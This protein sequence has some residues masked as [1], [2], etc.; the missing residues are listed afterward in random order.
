LQFLRVA[1][2]HVLDVRR[3]V[4]RSDLVP[5][6]LLEMVQPIRR[7]GPA[8]DDLDE[9]GGVALAG[10]PLKCLREFMA[11]GAGTPQLLLVL[12]E[13]RLEGDA[14]IDSNV[15]GGLAGEPVGEAA[16]GQPVQVAG[17]LLGGQARVVRKVGDGGAWTVQKQGVETL[18]VRR[19]AECLE[20][21][22]HPRLS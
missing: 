12:G 5:G 14:G 4:N 9:F 7:R 10:R 3:L 13:K 16:A 19:E 6:G 8:G 1:D 17:D 2:G 20:H 11:A 21:N 22:G 15:A 18:F